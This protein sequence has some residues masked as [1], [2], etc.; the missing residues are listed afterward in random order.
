MRLGG[1]AVEQR[2]HPDR[3]GAG[4]VLPYIVDEDA[5]RG[6]TPIRSAPSS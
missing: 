6:G 3:L 5:T 2:G 1:L 4:D